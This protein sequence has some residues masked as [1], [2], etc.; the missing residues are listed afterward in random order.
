ME[1]IFKSFL[2]FNFNAFSRILY[3][4]TTNIW[5]IFAVIGVGI[6]IVLSLRNVFVTTVREE[7]NIL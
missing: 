1:M 3:E 5:T 6:C 7:Q 4:F 2:V